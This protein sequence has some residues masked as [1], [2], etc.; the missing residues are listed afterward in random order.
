[1][2]SILSIILGLVI[3]VIAA[4]I[5]VNGSSALAKRLGISDLIIGL[6]IVACGT[7]MPEFFTSCIAAIK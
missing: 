4:D 6:T 2:L 3:L 7:S 1:M 5:L